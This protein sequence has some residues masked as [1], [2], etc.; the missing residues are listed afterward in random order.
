VS[1]YHIFLPVHII[2]CLA[3][4]KIVFSVLKTYR[5]WRSGTYLHG[6]YKCDSDRYCPNGWGIPAKTARFCFI[7]R[8]YICSV[9]INTSCLESG[10]IRLV[11]NIATLKSSVRLLSSN[12]ICLLSAIRPFAHSPLH[13]HFIREA[14]CV[15]CRVD[16][17]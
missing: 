9:P 2:S 5:A 7:S 8:H 13:T 14:L 3:H 15:R 16:Y 4:C 1:Y 17:T 10:N 12:E 6:V 11:S